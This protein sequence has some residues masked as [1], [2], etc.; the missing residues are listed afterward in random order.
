VDQPDLG[1]LV[2]ADVVDPQSNPAGE[3]AAIIL[4]SKHEHAAGK[5]IKVVVVSSRLTYAAKECMVMMPW[6]T[7]IASTETFSN[8]NLLKQVI[9]CVEKAHAAKKASTRP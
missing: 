6:A 9:A 5:P 1:K 3:H 7:A 8:G 2:W 4:T